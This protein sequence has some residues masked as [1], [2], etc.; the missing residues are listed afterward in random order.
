MLGVRPTTRAFV[1][2]VVLVA[3]VIVRPIGDAHASSTG[4]RPGAASSFLQQ[5][6][7][8]AAEAGY[9]SGRE[10]TV[11]CSTTA[12]DW[13]LALASAGFRSGEADQY[14][15]F[16]LIDRGVIHLSPYVCEGLRLGAKPSTRRQNELQVAWSVNVL[17]HESV[18]MARYTTDEALTEACARIALPAELHRLY[19]LPYR[20]AELSRLTL[21]ATWFRRSQDAVY[22]GGTCPANAR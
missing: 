17:I 6:V 22:R 20:S 12:G 9:L 13:A 5:G 19:K 7:W 10:V 18:H 2:L 16:S 4:V 11:T 21:A 14:Y 3:A 15:G 1:F 8:I